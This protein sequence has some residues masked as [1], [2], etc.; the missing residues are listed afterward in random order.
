[1]KKVSSDIKWFCD[2]LR[3]AEQILSNALEKAED[4]SDY[5]KQLVDRIESDV[6]MVDLTLLQLLSPI[7]PQ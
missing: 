2:Q 7:A 3:E 6:Q 1:M 4:F 5:D